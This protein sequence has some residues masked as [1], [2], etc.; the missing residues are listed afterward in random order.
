MGR[1]WNLSTHLPSRLHLLSP[2]PPPALQRAMQPLAWPPLPKMPVGPQWPLCLGVYF[3][4]RGPWPVNS[5]DQRA[6]SGSPDLLNQRTATGRG[7]WQRIAGKGSCGPGGRQAGPAPERQ[8]YRR[9][10]DR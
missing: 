10:S 2:P 3:L 9:E 8:G 4:F 7:C 6:G 1:R 5:G